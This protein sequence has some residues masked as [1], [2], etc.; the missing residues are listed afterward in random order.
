VNELIGRAYLEDAVARA[1]KR[2]ATRLADNLKKKAGE[3]R[4]DAAMFIAENPFAAV[5][6]G[7]VLGIAIGM[8]LPRLVPGKA[9]RTL[10]STARTAGLAYGRQAWDAA[11]RARA[12]AELVDRKDDE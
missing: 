2:N 10:A 12:E 8:M 7:L 6:G 5:A 4:D 9:L 1:Q 11:R 3:A